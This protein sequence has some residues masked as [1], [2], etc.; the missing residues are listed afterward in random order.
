MIE[1]NYEG[2][3]NTG[4]PKTTDETMRRQEWWSALS[5]SAGQLYG[6]GK[7][8]GFEDDDW[9][10]YLATKAVAQLGIMRTFL[11][12][13]PWF[14][15]VPDRSHAF[16]T[17]GFGTY[18]TE[19][20]VLD[21]DYATAAATPDGALGVVYVPTARTVTVDLS[22][23]RPDVVA[24]WFDPADGSVRPA[25]APFTTPGKNAEG[26]HDWVLVFESP[27]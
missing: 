22:K 26:T 2:E 18:G 4:G 5:G 6:H 8:W 11:E 7:T 9:R 1:A 27:R 16:V 12:R 15:L 25:T 20:D 10:Q 17:A 23:L 13:R 19:G 14:Q 3:N 21:N 24:T